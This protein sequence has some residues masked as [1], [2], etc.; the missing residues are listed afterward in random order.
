MDI[1]DKA[2][3]PASENQPKPAVENDG[4]QARPRFDRKLILTNAGAALGVVAGVYLFEEFKEE[5]LVIAY[6]FFLLMP[7]ALALGGV[8]GLVAQFIR[9][10]YR[11]RYTIRA[12][13]PGALA[14]GIGITYL[15][16][17]PGGPTGVESSGPSKRS[18]TVQTAGIL[19]PWP[20]LTCWC[21]TPRPVSCCWRLTAT[22]PVRHSFAQ[23]HS[24]PMAAKS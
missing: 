4:R 7:G 15:F 9:P 18:P 22:A 16:L 14:A 24:A 19:P 3:T 11:L 8:A 20:G 5:P 6:Y 17:R 23:L 21:G 12:L 13:L 2:S 10:L 1:D